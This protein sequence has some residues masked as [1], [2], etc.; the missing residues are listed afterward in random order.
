[1]IGRTLLCLAAIALVGTACAGPGSTGRRSESAREA[2]PVIYKTMEDAFQ[3]GDAEAIAQAYTED[4]EWY[5]PEAPVIKGRP[6]IA[7]AWKA[8]VG[9]GGNR[10]RIEVAEVEQSGDRAHE[11]GRFTI[12]GPD[13]AVLSAGKYIVIWAR[14]SDGEWKTRRD[15]FNWDI[16]PRQPPATTGVQ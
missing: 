13:G 6:A 12:S 11:V 16:P 8:N 5:V 3:E 7:R 9:S 10:L 1:M 4:A 2:I 14:Q 15:I